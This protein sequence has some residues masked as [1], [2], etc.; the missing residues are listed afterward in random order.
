MFDEPRQR[1][2]TTPPPAKQEEEV[3]FLSCLLSSQLAC[4]N[5][6]IFFFSESYFKQSFPR[7]NWIHTIIILP[8]PPSCIFQTGIVISCENYA[9]K[10]LCVVVVNFLIIISKVV[11]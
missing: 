1:N 11:E 7:F 6:S 5:P 3:L 4:Y 10:C 8:P 2:S 9:L